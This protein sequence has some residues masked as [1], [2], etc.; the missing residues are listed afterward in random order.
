MSTTAVSNSI[1]FSSATCELANPLQRTPSTIGTES[2]SSSDTLL[3]HFASPCGSEFSKTKWPSSDVV[4]LRGITRAL[5]A[6]E[7]RENTR[8]KMIGVFIFPSRL[9]D[10]YGVVV[11]AARLTFVSVG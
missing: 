6:T 5:S 3:G 8:R 10:R 9:V 7:S 2:S 1:C 4:Y 11:P